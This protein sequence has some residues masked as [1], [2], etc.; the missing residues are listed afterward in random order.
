MHWR[1]Y[2]C[3][4]AACVLAPVDSAYAGA[5]ALK[6]QAGI[7]GLGRAGRWA[8]VRV[9]IDNTDRDFSGD[10]VVAWGDAV[11]RRAITLASPSRADLVLYVRTADV[12]GVISVRVESNDVLQQSIDVPIRLQAPDDEVTLCVGV[13]D[14]GQAREECAATVSAA[15]LPRSMWGYDAVDRLRWE[16][17]SPDALDRDQRVALDRWTAKRALDEA[18]AAF[19]SPSPLPPQDDVGGRPVRL[20]AVGTVV[21][22]ALLIAATA[23]ARHLRRRPLVVYGVIAAF[24]VLGSAA[25]LAAGRLG[26]SA[27]IVVTH[28]SRVDQLSTGGSLVAIKASAQYPTFD[29]FALR[30]ALTE[31]AIAP[32]NGS[33]APLRFN[34]SGEPMVPGQFGLASRQAFELDG[35][36]SFSPFRVARQDGIV[37]VANPSSFDYHDC[38]LS[39]GLSRQA[40]GL[41]RAGQTVDARSSTSGG[42]IACRLAATPVKFEESRY[43]VEVE[44]STDVVAYLDPLIRQ[45]DK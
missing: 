27:A 5:L 39:D 3:A 25:A 14:A 42:F 34:E 2:V 26:P 11:V 21:Y 10:V 6:A 44:G 28:S 43:A 1:V 30:A 7:G 22:L 33:P 23:A 37:T 41:L 15:A 45:G 31:S 4:I 9:S 32:K 40:L 29:T 35:V 16:G 36:V 17:T 24:A 12:R 18:G 20:A 19:A 38:Y 8:P 13:S